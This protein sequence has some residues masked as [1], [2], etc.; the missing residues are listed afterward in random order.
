[1]RILGLVSFLDGGEF[2]MLSEAKHLASNVEA[3]RLRTWR[4][5]TEQIFRC[6]QDDV[7]RWCMF[8]GFARGGI[9]Q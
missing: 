8:S 5:T 4:R 6:A 1:M 2:V 7:V 9:G 3:T